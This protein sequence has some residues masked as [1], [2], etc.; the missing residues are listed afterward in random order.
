MRHSTIAM[1]RIVINSVESLQILYVDGH[2]RIDQHFV[3]LVPFTQQLFTPIFVLLL[4]T[5]GII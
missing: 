5:K 2:F 1:I 3:I 4:K